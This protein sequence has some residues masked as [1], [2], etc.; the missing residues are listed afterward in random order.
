[1][2]ECQNKTKKACCKP[3]KSQW[4]TFEFQTLSEIRTFCVCPKNPECPK[5]KLACIPI[6]ALPEIWT[7]GFQTFTVHIC[8]WEKHGLFCSQLYGHNLCLFL[9]LNSEFNFF[10]GGRQLENLWFDELPTFRRRCRCSQNA[11]R[12]LALLV[13]RKSSL[14]YCKSQQVII[15]LLQIAATCVLRTI[16]FLSYVKNVIVYFLII[17]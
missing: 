2:W 10:S 15:R 13:K 16:F 4:Y 14:G 17:F 1:M 3:F 8:S 12:R 6:L 11:S 7:F 9:T 5:F